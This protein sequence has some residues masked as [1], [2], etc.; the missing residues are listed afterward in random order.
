M[1]RWG[2]EVKRWVSSTGTGERV[3]SSTVLPFHRPTLTGSRPS[4]ALSYH[5]PSHSFPESHRV[6]WV[7]PGGGVPVGPW[8]D[9]NDLL[10]GTETVFWDPDRPRRRVPERG[11][12]LFYPGAS[13][14]PEGPPG[15]VGPATVLSRSTPTPNLLH[16]LKGTTHI[17]L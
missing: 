1:S 10:D 11:S 5:S 12:V 3:S 17:L 8:R 6:F 7:G 2:V 14:V 13:V 4:G 9:R 15:P 16:R